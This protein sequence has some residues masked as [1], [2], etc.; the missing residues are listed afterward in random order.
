VLGAVFTVDCVRCHDQLERHALQLAN[1]R[2]I[3]AYDHALGQVLCASRRRFGMSLYLNKA[4]AA[5]GMWCDIAYRAQV[6]YVDT[7]V[8]RGEEQLIALFRLYGTP[9][10]SDVYRL[11]SGHGN[12][13]SLAWARLA[14]VR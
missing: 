8:K 2:R 12:L 4:Q 13:S 9:V 3:G 1:A 11:F 5:S 7:R 14:A 6:R 10:N